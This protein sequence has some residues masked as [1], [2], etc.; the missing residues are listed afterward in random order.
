MKKFTKHTGKAVVLN[1][2]DVDT[3]QIIPKQFLKKIDRTSFGIHLFHDWRF[4]DDAGSRPNP[5]FELNKEIANG[6][7]ILVTGANFGCGSSRE[8]APWALQDYGFCAILAPSFADIF[9]SNCIKNGLL[10]IS[11]TIQEIESIME[12]LGQHPQTEISIDLDAQTVS[13]ATK[14]ASYHFDIDAF[15]KENLLQGVDEIDL[16][17]EHASK[18][19]EFEKQHL[20][21]YTFYAINS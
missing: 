13:G 19:S 9:Y 4:L 5:D 10:P 16:S 15:Q 18:I 8:H 20:S 21:K 3:D 1:R 7:S 2:S 6:T 17:L 14:E 12:Y 11:L